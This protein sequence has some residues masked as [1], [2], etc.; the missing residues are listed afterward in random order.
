MRKQG[1][2]CVFACAEYGGRAV[3]VDGNASPHGAHHASVQ[4]WPWSSRSSG[5]QACAARDARAIRLVLA[6]KVQACEHRLEDEGDVRH[7]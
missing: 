6:R 7:S 1:R 3:K 2:A 4:L 5:G